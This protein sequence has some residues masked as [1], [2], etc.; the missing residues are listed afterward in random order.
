MAA[1]GD[2]FTILALFLLAACLVAWS[3][4]GGRL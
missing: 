3:L 4:Y 1:V 2:V